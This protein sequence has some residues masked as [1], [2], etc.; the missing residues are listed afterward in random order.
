M[1]TGR[2]VSS[3]GTALLLPLL[4]ILSTVCLALPGLNQ[5]YCRCQCEV[6]TM[7]VFQIDPCDNVAGARSLRFQD[8]IDLLLPLIAWGLM[9]GTAKLASLPAFAAAAMCLFGLVEPS[10]IT[11][12]GPLP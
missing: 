7:T 4:K 6:H 11:A 9:R 10:V 8:L 12:G 3:S 5:F 1:L 2:M